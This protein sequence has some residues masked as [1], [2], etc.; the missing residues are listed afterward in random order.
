VFVLNQIDRIRGMDGQVMDALVT[1]LHLDGYSEPVVVATSASPRDG[2]DPDVS[3]LA[4]AVEEHL[5][6]KT[7]ALSKLAVD[8]RSIA[9]AGWHGCRE[10]GADAG[11]DEDRWHAALAAA[12]F[13]TLGVA[14]YELHAR[15]TPERGRR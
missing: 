1:Q 3:A 2:V 13:V 10:A 6:V 7:T 12:T 8:L 5:D 14:A 4:A 15:T 9:N 11:N